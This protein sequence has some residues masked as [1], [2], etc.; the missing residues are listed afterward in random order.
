M[1]QNYSDDQMLLDTFEMNG[2]SE[3]KGNTTNC[4][5]LDK[6]ER[7]TK[8]SEVTIERDNDYLAD[9]LHKAAEHGNKATNGQSNGKHRG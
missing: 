2:N 7:K 4:N 5:V 9:E 3:A 6:S 1:F 8:K